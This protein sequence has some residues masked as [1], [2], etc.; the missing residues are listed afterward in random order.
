MFSQ[1][2][3]DAPWL[4]T[5]TTA[6]LNVYGGNQASWEEALQEHSQASYFRTSWVYAGKG[7]DFAENDVAPRKKNA[8]SWL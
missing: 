6:P 5:D 1:A 4:E 2:T 7:N 3:V 8:K